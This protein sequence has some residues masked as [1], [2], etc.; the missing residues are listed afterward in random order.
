M[1]FR[2]TDEELGVDVVIKLLKPRM[3][4]DELRA[5][6]VQ[7]AQAAAQVRHSNLVRVFGT[8]KLD[9][10]AYIVMELL[11]GPNLEQYLR[12][13]RGQ[14]LPWREALA[15]LLPA[16]AALHAV[17]EQGYVHRDIKTGN[18][19]VTRP[20]GHPA[21]AIVIDLGLVKPDRALRTVDSPPTT[22]VGRMLC[23]PGYASPEQAAGD[24]VD[25]RSDIYSLA[26]TLYRVLA[27]RLP[28]HDARGQPLALLAR[29]IYNAP[30]RL[31]AA[32]A[33]AEVPP[34]IAA[35]IESALRK[36]PNDR[37]QT[38]L[39]FAEALQA[40]AAHSSSSPPRR[41][42]HVFLLGLGLGVVLTWLAIPRP[43]PPV[44]IT[45]GSDSDHD[46]DLDHDHDL[47]APVIPYLS[48]GPAQK[49]P[50]P[51]TEPPEAPEQP[52]RGGHRQ[53]N[54]ARRRALDASPALA[55]CRLNYGSDDPIELPVELAV[56]ASG[57]VTRARIQL[58]D[59]TLATAC[60]EAA[61]L[62]SRLAPGPAREVFHHTIQGGRS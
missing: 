13:Y 27:G 23:T 44:A 31:A 24:P 35:V 46:L 61:L 17:H 41:R 3:A 38:M 59:V 9:S 39:A 12:E 32:A 1:S 25:R 52:A 36:N 11:D 49:N 62:G 48:P 19:L 30:T 29:H 15:L 4:S 14:R 10:T 8:G 43:A 45:L 50:E 53:R 42:L 18:I 6:M 56:E 21:T 16:L 58:R 2:A 40:A 51:R 37:P 60:F 34:A 57:A 47:D 55:A 22:E 7:E 26:I 54:A 28:F 33:G 5:R 20:A